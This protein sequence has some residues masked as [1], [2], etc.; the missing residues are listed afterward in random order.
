MDAPWLPPG[1]RAEVVFDPGGPLPT[2]TALVRLL[3]RRDDALFCIRRTGSGKLDLPTA[4]VQ[5]GGDG[6]S[7]VLTLAHD[8]L[9]CAAPVMLVGYVRNIVDAA[10]GDYA[11][12]TP[13]AHF[14]VWKADG[15]PV[16]Q[17]S[18]LSVVDPE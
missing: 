10:G 5:E 6:Q 12:P 4:S 8:V 1:G 18:W 13:R 7:A 16:I 9:G 15:L 11:W 17:G 3:I 14:C 2:P